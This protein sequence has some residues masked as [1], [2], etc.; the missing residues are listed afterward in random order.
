MKRKAK[1]TALLMCGILLLSGC[2]TA[3]DDAPKDKTDVVNKATEAPAETPAPDTDTTVPTEAPVDPVETPAPTETPTDVTETPAPTEAPTVSEVQSNIPHITILPEEKTMY[4][5]DG[6]P[7]LVVKDYTLSISGEGFEALQNS[8]DT[9]HPG[10]IEEDHQFLYESAL[11]HYEFNL[12]PGFFNEYSS[13]VNA[14]LSRC[15]SSIVSF[16][17]HYSD[18]T[19]G[20][21]GMFAYGGETYDVETG[22]QLL[23]ADIVAD[24][25]GF[26]PSAIDYISNALYEEYEDA[27]FADYQS[28]VAESLSPDKES[29]WYMT[30]TGIVICFSPYE[31]GP[32]A[33]G[34]PEIT[35]PYSECAAYLHSKYLPSDGELV[36]K[37]GLNQDISSLIGTEQPIMIEALDNDWQIDISLVSGSDKV[38][39]G[40]FNY[41]IDGYIIKRADG[42]SFIII[43]CDYMSADSITYLY[44]ITDGNL[45]AR[46]EMP[47]M[48]L[49]GTNISS[50]R[51]EMTV[52]INALGSF[53]G[54]TD[55]KLTADGHL[56]HDDELYQITVGYPLSI[57]KPLPVTIDGTQTTLDAGTQ[58]AI[59]GTNL[60]DEIYFK[61]VGSNQTGT[62][63]YTRD[64]QTGFIIY[65]NGVSEYEY[66]EDL[67][68]AG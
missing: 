13:Y 7:V 38:S 42:R 66:F 16:R 29:L 65:I 39:F 53:G 52:A 49:S 46:N 11:D 24:T 47:N 68:Y 27:L 22:Q 18:Y 30:A 67:P 51:I 12:T 15:D 32:Y 9:V 44:E 60:L 48:H 36:A 23:L 61:V 45:V 14:A 25:E 20:A 37:V 19:G 40:T 6:T 41:F 4:A 35:L 26:Y 10:I 31:V 57:I 55:Y 3:T 2:S 58:I 21:H 33:M 50:E 28:W 63:H 64:E 17:T 59:T 5:E 34:A 8:F 54:C 56:V 43:S 62:I 1:W